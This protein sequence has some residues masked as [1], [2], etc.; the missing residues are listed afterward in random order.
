[1]QREVLEPYWMQWILCSMAQ[2]I[3]IECT[4][5]NGASLNA[6]DSMHCVAIDPYCMQWSQWSEAKC[7]PIE[8]TGLYAAWPKASQL[9]AVDSMQRQWMQKIP[10]LWRNGSRLYAVESMQCDECMDSRQPGKMHPDW[11]QWI[12]C[13]VIECSGFHAAWLNAVDSMQ[14]GKMHP[15]WMQWI[16]CSVIECRGFHALWR[17][18]SRFYAVESM[19]CDWMQ[20]NP[21]SVVKCIPLNAVDFMQH[22]PKHP[23]W[24]SGFHAVWCNWFSLNALIPCIKAQWFLIECTGF[25]AAF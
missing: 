10:A 11:M 4:G 12:P 7:I 15:D 3:L 6:E 24:V 16:P 8:C 5:F 19:H 14:P 22:G 18:G 23:D 20:C 17:N 13:S 1:M 25:H 21:C 9:N 2:S